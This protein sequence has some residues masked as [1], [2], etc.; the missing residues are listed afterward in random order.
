MVE[1]QTKMIFKFNKMYKR[2][3]DTFI[4]EELDLEYFKYS[5]CSKKV[6]KDDIE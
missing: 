1:K 3:I 6:F 5:K 2:D 4:A